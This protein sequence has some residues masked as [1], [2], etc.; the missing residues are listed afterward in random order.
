MKLNPERNR[1]RFALRVHVHTDV[2]RMYKGISKQG[3]Y[4]V[5][6]VI[7]QSKTFRFSMFDHTPGDVGAA[8]S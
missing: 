7:L 6:L 5:A 1:N 2:Q 4:V 8:G 3:A